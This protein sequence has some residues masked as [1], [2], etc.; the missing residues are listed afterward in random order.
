VIRVGSGLVA[1]AG[2]GT[3]AALLDRLAHAGI[4]VP[5]GVVVA[6]GEPTPKWETLSL[7]VPVVVRSAF[8]AEDGQVSA[9]AGRFLSVLHVNRSQ[10]PLAVDEVRDSVHRVANFAQVRTDVLVMEQVAAQHAGVAFSEPGWQDDVVNVIDGLADGLVSGVT[11]GERFDLSRLN[12][13]HKEPSWHARLRCVLQQVRDELGDT[14]WD[15]E[16]ADD[17]THCWLVQ[18][19]P[20]TVALRRD[21]VFTVAN[22]KE[23]LPALPSTYM[24]SVVVACQAELFAWYRRFDGRLPANR[25]FIEAIAG[26]PFLNLSLLEDML[27][28]WGLP[29][30]LVADSFGGTSVHNEPANVRRLVRSAPILLRQGL[31]QLDAIAR[32]HRLRKQL[33]RLVASP[34]MTLA[35][36]A[37]SAQDAYVMLVT[38]M[39]PLS[40]FLSG[41]VS[42]LRRAGVL[43]EHGARLETISTQMSRASG[44]E[45]RT[46]FGHR[47]IYES[48]LARPR[49]ADVAPTDSANHQ[50]SPSAT[51]PR[52]TWRGILTIPLWTLTRRG[53]AVR[54]SH[55]HEC[56]RAFHSVRQAIVE[57]SEQLVTSGVFRT[58]D[59]VW[60]LTLDETVRVE[61]G[62][63]PTPQ[64]WHEREQQR[65]AEGAVDPPDTV[66]R[67]DDPSE[68][69]NSSALAQ[70]RWSGIP[71]TYGVVRG[72]AWVLSEPSSTVPS[73]VTSPIVVVARS[74][75]AGWAITFPLAAGVAVETGGDLSHGSIVLRELGKPAVTNLREITRSIQTGEL[76]ELDAQQGTVRRVLPAP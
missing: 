37:Q 16:W 2:V 58:V 21:E 61:G 39:I 71:L 56:M 1:G 12:P 6:H 38:G 18:C 50:S 48:D 51:L 28:L 8:S 5:S 25:A 31:A 15:I 43:Q 67:F 72:T 45:L 3:K 7:R 19:R 69:G 46:T 36:Q 35:T 22:H 47:G 49:F 74:V 73:N 17:G 40:S 30:R 29:S 20:I 10:F 41:P 24:T 32:P 42:I 27:R 34:G 62:W 11:Q 70:D 4:P 64:F 23:I 9:N 54:E 14:G 53:L 76:I 52:R 75:D 26:R 60:L 59:D 55:R 65:I 33:R 57:R 13:R 63:K 44:S 68:W 66:N